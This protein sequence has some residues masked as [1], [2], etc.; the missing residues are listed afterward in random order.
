MATSTINDMK[1]YDDLA[2]GA[3]YE[4]ISQN[5]NAFNEASSGSLVLNAEFKQGDYAK[6]SFFKNFSGLSRRDD[7][8]TSAASAAKLIQ[9]ENISVKLKRKFLAE[10]T[11]DSFRSLGLTMD[12]FAMMCGEQMA[13]ETR[14][15]ALERAISAIDAFLAAQT[16][17]N[18]DV[19]G[20]GSNTQLSHINLNEALKL[21]GD[22][23]S[24]IGAWVMSGAAFHALLGN[25]LGG[26]APQFNDSGI[27]VYNG[28]VPTLGRPVLVTDSATLNPSGK[29]VVLGLR[30]AAAI[31]TI[32]EATDV[33]IDDVSG[34]ENLIKRFQAEAAYNL[35]LRGAKWSGSRNP[36]S[37]SVSTAGNWTANVTSNKDLP[38]VRLVVQ[39]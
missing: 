18:L 26:T 14:Q 7:T 19:S 30:D 4:R 12:D 6:Q 17:N 8:S 16:G 31:A 37:A 21:M 36:V 1:V 28:G 25:M 15:E 38:G 33:L 24:S 9:D 22:K 2:V 13:D 35:Q 34:G 3:F 11:R 32:T 23:S 5:I 10:V 27:S 29:F 20:N 39:Q